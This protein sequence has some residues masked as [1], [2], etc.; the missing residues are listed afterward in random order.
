M[1]MLW[2]LLVLAAIVWVVVTVAPYVFLITMVA[3]GG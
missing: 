2:D 1:R 3:N